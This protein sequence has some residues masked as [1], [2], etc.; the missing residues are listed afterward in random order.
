M[1]QLVWQ[2][3]VYGL[4]ELQLSALVQNITS[5]D[6][7]FFLFPCQTLFSNI[8]YAQRYFQ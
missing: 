8:K 3:S 6:G 7:F 2:V 1:A 4:P 5:P